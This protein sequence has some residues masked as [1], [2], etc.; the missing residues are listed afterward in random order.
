VFSGHKFTNNDAGITFSNNILVRSGSRADVYNNDF[1]AI[2]IMSGVRNITFNNTY[3]YDSQHDAVE[4]S[5]SP[6]GIVF[7][8]LQIFGTG[9]DGQTT[10][11]TGNGSAFKFPS[12]TSSQPV[13]INGFTYGNIA[14]DSAFF[15]Q[16]T[17]CSITNEEDKGKDAEYTVLSGKTK[18]AG[19]IEIIIDDNPEKESA[20]QETTKEPATQKVTQKPTQKV[21]TVAPTK[22]A[23]ISKVYKKKKASKKLKIKIKKFTGAKIYKIQVSKSKSF[24]KKNILLS[25]DSKRITKNLNSKKLKNRKKLYVR[26]MACKYNGNKIV[27]CSKWSKAVKVKI[28]K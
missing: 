2:D 5:G 27:A 17:G 9:I 11:R 7:N 25:K 10:G 28:V 20:T 13:T 3:I 6:S 26:V 21:T 19:S 15:G 18:A 1:G 8:N 14:N 4:L 24:K 23:K 22:K 16:R 12:S